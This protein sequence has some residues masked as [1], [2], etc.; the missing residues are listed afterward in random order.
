MRGGYV[1]DTNP[2]PG[3][4]PKVQN[5][6]QSISVL[7]TSPRTTSIFSFSCPY[8]Y[9]VPSFSHR[10]LKFDRLFLSYLVSQNF[11]CIL[12]SCTYCFYKPDQACPF[13]PV[14]QLYIH[15][16]TPSSSLLL[17]LCVSYY[18]SVLAT[19]LGLGPVG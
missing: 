13:L 2:W 12:M 19:T 18:Y 7:G 6:L 10:A 8:I 15:I 11:S 5:N 16:Y 1:E 14:L 9:T 17:F 3:R 4:T